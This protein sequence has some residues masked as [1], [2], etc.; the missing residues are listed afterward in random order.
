MPS[1]YHSGFKTI[2]PRAAQLVTE[3]NERRQLTFTLADVESITG[4][5]PASARSW[6][7]KARARGLITRLKPGLFNLVPFELGRATEHVGNPYIIAQEL[8]ASAEY[9]ISW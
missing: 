6:V 4:L 7:Q 3:L 9:F 5:C 1:E 2:G 8:A